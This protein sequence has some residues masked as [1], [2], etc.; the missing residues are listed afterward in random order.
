MPTF[1]FKSNHYHFL[2]SISKKFRSLHLKCYTP[3]IFLSQYYPSK[4]GHS[5]NGSFSFKIDGR[6]KSITTCQSN[7]IEQSESQ[8]GHRIGHLVWKHQ[9]FQKCYST[10]SFWKY[11][12]GAKIDRIFIKM[13][14]VLWYT[15]TKWLAKYI[16]QGY[17]YF[18]TQIFVILLTNSS[19]A[20]K[21][22]ESGRV[23][24]LGATP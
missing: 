6:K 23:A 1:L 16:Q 8:I 18:Q 20:P 22:P 13:T 9:A 3:N 10:F 19:L 14:K 2:F 11:F 21:R 12:C 7:I 5:L 4:F 17:S 15:G 24:A